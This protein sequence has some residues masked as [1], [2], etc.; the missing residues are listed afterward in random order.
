MLALVPYA[1]QDKRHLIWFEKKD[2]FP[3]VKI[4]RTEQL[5]P[6][7]SIKSSTGSQRKR[8]RKRNL[9]WFF[10]VKLAL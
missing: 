9:F 10:G 5:A 1:T 4:S 3:E 7:Q 2:R 6:K 8:P